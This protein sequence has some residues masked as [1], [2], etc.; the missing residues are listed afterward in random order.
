MNKTVIK[1]YICYLGNLLLDILFPLIISPYI[2]R[3]LGA[4]RVGRV[5][6]ANSI[7]AWFVLIAAIGIPT[8]GIREVAKVKGEKDRLQKL[9]SELVIIR[10]ILTL[11][12]VI[13]FVVSIFCITKL[14]KEMILYLAMVLNLLL[15]IFSVDWFFQ[16]IEKYQYLTIRNMFFKIIT[17]TFTILLV[18]KTND[19]I[20][21]AYIQVI[22]LGIFNIINFVTANKYSKLTFKELNLRSHFNKL[23]VFF[24]AALIT[25]IYTIFDSIVVGFMLDSVSLAFYSRSRQVITMGLTLTLSLSTVLIPTVSYLYSSDIKEFIKIITK[26]LKY[27][28]MISIPLAVGI[29]ILSEEIM[30]FFGGEEFI[31]GSPIMLGMA[32][33]VVFDSVYTW[34]ANQILIPTGNEKKS[35]LIQLVMAGVNLTM[36]F[37]LIKYMGIIGA[38]L[39]LL[40]TE[41][42]GAI[43]G[44]YFVNR[45]LDINIKSIN[46]SKYIIAAIFMGITVKII[47]DIIVN[48]FLALV[49]SVIIGA[50]TYFVILIILKENDVNEAVNLIKSK[51]IHKPMI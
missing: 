42:A 50:F 18:R 23:K 27:I 3:V 47:K 1:N 24:A 25:S 33:I 20:L 45:L 37:L 21:Y 8:Y 40:L 39:S 51:I 48:N 13:I 19:Y 29:A 12:G 35:V 14:N 5:N 41:I 31:K 44:I 28:L 11:V 30:Y 9:F 46:L 15:Y 36:N 7:S 16:G 2:T 49:A 4:D 32:L 6:L 38:V 22:S 34:A 43:M 26:S 17:L 10:G